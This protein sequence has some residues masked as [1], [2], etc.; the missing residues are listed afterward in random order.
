MEGDLNLSQA[1][2]GLRIA[3][4]TD[5]SPPPSPSPSPQPA[6]TVYSSG[7]NN[8]AASSQS[9]IYIP[10]L[11]SLE[12]NSPP[13]CGVSSNGG[14][15]S[16]FHSQSAPLSQ[17]QFGPPQP[18]SNYP[19]PSASSS[20]H[21]SQIVPSYTGAASPF[22]PSTP[23]GG[24]AASL[25]YPD[26]SS[27]ATRISR[28]PSRSSLSGPPGAS[29]S[30]PRP[31]RERSNTDRTY[32]QSTAA[33]PSPSFHGDN[34]A[35]GGSSSSARNP[36]EAEHGIP[37]SSEEWKEKGAAVGVK[38]EIDANGN[39]VTR[40][41]K[42]GVKDFNFGRTLGEGSYSTVSDGLCIIP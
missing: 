30:G 37:A 3:N 11:Q 10:D 23:G 32:R 19:P 33:G 20:R 27:N 16:S 36:Y 40:A 34:G 15:S 12:S 24:S 41:V 35:R 21:S 6:P 1:L 31:P 25:K 39:V 9:Q 7:N 42:K 5:D 8:N 38:K 18:R 26:Y 28:E 29:G 2:G 14:Q 17:T 4:Q 13:T 22:P